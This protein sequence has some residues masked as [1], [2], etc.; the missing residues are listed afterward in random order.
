M[1]ISKPSLKEGYPTLSLMEIPNMDREQRIRIYGSPVFPFEPTILAD[2][3]WFFSPADNSI[4][5]K[6]TPFDS[7][8]IHNNSS[9]TVKVEFGDSSMFVYAGQSREEKNIFFEILKI[10][11]LSSVDITAGELKVEIK[12]AAMDADKLAKERAAGFMS[13]FSMSGGI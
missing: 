6:Y 7:F 8:V 9:S 11:E 5:A 12:R 10:T 4:H 3:S 13:G 2:K 1:G